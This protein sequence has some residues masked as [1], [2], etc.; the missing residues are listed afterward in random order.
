M[1]DLDKWQEIFSTISKNKLRTFLTGF[2]VAWGIFML[3]ILLGSGNGL[4]HGA[5]NQFAG[6]AVNSIW[7]NPGQTALPYQ[8]Y[9]PGRDIRLQNS[10]LE[11]IGQNIDGIYNLSARKYLYGNKMATYKDKAGSFDVLGCHPGEKAAE[12]IQ[13]LGGR[14]VN[15]LDVNEGRKIAC[16]GRDMKV[17]LFGDQDPLGKYININ[18]IPFKVVGWYMDDGGERDVRRAWV[19]ISTHQRVFG[20]PNRIDR[21]VMTTGDATVEEANAIVSELR[22]RLSNR[23]HFDENDQ[24]AVFISNR[25]EHFQK[26]ADLFLGIRLFVV[27]IGLGTILAGV[28][29]V[30]NIMMIVV[31]ERTKE[32]GIR[33]AMGATS[34]SIISLIMQESI[35]ITT[36]AGYIGLTLGVLLLEM[37]GGLIQGNDYFQNPEVDLPTAI[38]ATLALII[39]GSIAGLIPALRASK[40]E[41][42]IALRED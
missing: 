36:I 37:V 11:D 8:G 38:Y 15:Q 34:G 35:F 14:F 3:I 26:F 31:K 22:S 41:P 6:D 23:L 42:V 25:A 2:S 13:I 7:I 27:F 20:R 19:P 9:K 33:K 32:I 21:I 29:G 5:E 17:E 30:S 39:A 4:Q 24:R 12:Q 1:F 16:L 40:I 18:G 28:V 10:D